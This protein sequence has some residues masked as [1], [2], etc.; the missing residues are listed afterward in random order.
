MVRENRTLFC[1]QDVK[2]VLGCCNHCGQEVLFHISGKTKLPV[3]C[4]L[5]AKE[6]FFGFRRIEEEP[7]YELLSTLQFLYRKNGREHPPAVTL[8]LVVNE[9]EENGKEEG[10]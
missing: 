7:E 10:R 8:K 4:P 6:W 3:V 9:D 5:C 2:G 1:I